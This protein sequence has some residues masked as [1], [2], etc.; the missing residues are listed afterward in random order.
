[1]TNTAQRILAVEAISECS[2]S[3]DNGQM[4]AIQTGKTAT[5]SGSELGTGRSFSS[6]AVTLPTGSANPG[7]EAQT[8]VCTAPGFLDT[9][10]SCGGPD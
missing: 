2:M 9:S 7:N 10:L 4:P 1:M 5:A 3:P 8:G 6:D